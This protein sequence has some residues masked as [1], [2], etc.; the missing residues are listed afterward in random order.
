MSKTNFLRSLTAA[1]LAATVFATSS[2]L[3]LA[4]PGKAGMGELIVSG[5]S[6]VTINGEA[7][8]TGRTVFSSNTI[9][10]TADAGATVN[11]GKLGQIELAPNS[12]LNLTFNETSISGALLNGRVKVSGANDI[13]ANIHTK[14]GFVIA[15]SNQAKNFTVSFDGAKT[16]VASEAG[17]VTL[18]EN[19]S[20]IKVGQ[21]QTD[22]DDND[23]E[24]GFF[25]SGSSVIYAIVFGA[26]AAAI[27]YVAV[28]GSNE[29][30]LSG[31]STP[32]SPTR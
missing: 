3:A 9:A 17:V 21:Q 11:L 27:I 10:T 13:A 2:M 22:D 23:S 7:A 29:V 14:T 12:S 26:A 32:V 28:D 18:T 5:G 4:A 16:N 15:E 1:S 19:G 8:N 24:G 25:N 30:N 20:A 6:A 31:G